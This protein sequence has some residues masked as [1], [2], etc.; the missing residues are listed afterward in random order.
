MIES[1]ERLTHPTY[2]QGN[3]MSSTQPLPILSY[4]TGAGW[5]TH[6]HAS[7][8]SGAAAIIKKI[9]SDASNSLLK[10]HGFKL[11]VAKRTDLHRELNGGP[12]GFVWS[13]GKVVNTT[14][15]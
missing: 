15:S 7:T 12:A 3:I 10:T 4:A 13:I 5:T 2:L 11:I 6:G 9:I 1:L 8:I 14:R